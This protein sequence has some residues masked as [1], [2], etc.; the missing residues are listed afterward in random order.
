LHIAAIVPAYNEATRLPGVLA[1]LVKATELDEIIVV[2]DGSQDDTY[3]VAVQ[4]PGVQAIRLDKNRGKGGALLAGVQATKADILLF[5]DADLSGLTAGHVS[6][7]V[8]PV[9]RDEA[10]MAVGV[11]RGGRFL[12]DLAQIIAPQISGQRCLYRDVFLRA[13]QVAQMRFGIEIG[14]Y[15]FA[16]AEGLRIQSVVLTGITHP[17]KEEKLGVWRGACARAMMYSDIGRALLVP[18]LHR[19]GMR[20]W[21]LLRNHSVDR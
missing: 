1:P 16:V 7:L 21:N 11:F 5:I 15:R 3:E 10:D 20:A 18:T 19:Q 14:L 9:V 12:T 6:K 4:H 17:M 2:S 8:D 13:S